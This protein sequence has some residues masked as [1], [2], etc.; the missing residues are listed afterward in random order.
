[1][2][3]EKLRPQCWVES[4]LLPQSFKFTCFTLGKWTKSTQHPAFAHRVC[5][6]RNNGTKWPGSILL[7]L[8][9]PSQ[10]TEITVTVNND[11]NGVRN[12][13]ARRQQQKSRAR[14]PRH[15]ATGFFTES[16]LSSNA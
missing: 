7:R 12:F 8:V 5:K 10:A 16:S 6:S 14:H 11:D 4:E 9:K 3:C 13:I 1:M 15:G 2:C